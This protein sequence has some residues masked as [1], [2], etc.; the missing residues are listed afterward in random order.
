MEQW[1]VLAVGV[2]L[3]VVA[4]VVAYRL[5]RRAR[6]RRRVWRLTPAAALDEVLRLRCQIRRRQLEQDLAAVGRAFRLPME[7]TS[8]SGEDE[9]LFELFDGKLDGFFIEVGA[10]DGKTNSV[11]YPFEAVGWNG[12]LVEPLEREFGMCREARP[13]SRVV[14][15]ALGPPPGPGFSDRARFTVVRGA[16]RSGQHSFLGEDPAEARRL[17]KRGKTIEHVDVPVS[18]LDALLAEQPPPGGIDFA[19]IDVEGGELNLLRGFDLARWRP[20]VLL[21]EDWDR[22]ADD[23]VRQYVEQRGYTR[24]GRQRHNSVFVRSDAHDV[25]RR[26]LRMTRPA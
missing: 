7:F 14:N 19:S 17:A 5:H 25:V 11:S 16:T 8:E 3:G 12:L 21:I 23:L 24:C 15:A 13:Y 22:P 26:A 4:G 1:I 18:C 6:Q 2:V 9:F 10:H 20:T